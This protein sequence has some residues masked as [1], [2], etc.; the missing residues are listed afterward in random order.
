MGLFNLFKKKPLFN[1]P[2]FGA[3]KHHA[4]K[5]ESLFEGR[6]FFTPA[7]REIGLTIYA[8]ATGL[9]QAQYDFYSTIEHDYAVLV[10]KIIPLIEDEFRNW[11]DDFVI[12]DFAKEFTLEHISIPKLDTRTLKWQI[13]FTS[14]HDLNHHFTIDFEGMEPAAVMIDG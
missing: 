10:N 14:I 9:I 11:K 13:S 8:E 7:G 5:K 12:K 3:L 6:I 4:F 1:D 2:F